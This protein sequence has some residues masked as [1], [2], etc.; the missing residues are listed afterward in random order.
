MWTATT[1]DQRLAIL[2]STHIGRTSPPQNLSSLPPA[3][4]HQVRYENLD[5]HTSGLSFYSPSRTRDW[6]SC[7]YHDSSGMSDSSAHP[8]TTPVAAIMAKQ[9]SIAPMPKPY[10][11]AC[12]VLKNWGPMMLPTAITHKWSQ[13]SAF[14][15]KND[16]FKALTIEDRD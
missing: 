2:I 10:L 11:G 7:Q 5:G 12:D 3:E 13:N 14:V 1:V 15:H 4:M 6:K 16:C 9:Q 8:Y